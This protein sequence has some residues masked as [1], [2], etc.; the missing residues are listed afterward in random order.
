MLADIIPPM[1]PTSLSLLDRLQTAPQ[2]EDWSRLVALYQPFIARY[3]RFDPLLAQDADD[4]CQEVM[5]KLV[6]HLPRFRR[7]RHGSF[8]AWLRTIT[9]N[10]VN[11]YWRQRA[12]RL[13]LQHTDGQTVLAELQD[14]RHEMSRLWDQEHGEYVV[15]RLQEL[16]EPEFSSTTW[17]AFRMRVHEERPTADVAAALGI[18]K[19]AV[20][21]AK[22]RVLNRLRQEAGVLL[23][24]SD[25]S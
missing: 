17:Q 6:E 15:A 23:D 22:S 1:E 5:L 24:L 7:Q 19:N 12:R 14:P 21:I 16:I 8:R 4:T 10:E 13:G 18:S 3:F 20:D 9:V 25:S 11:L 2:P